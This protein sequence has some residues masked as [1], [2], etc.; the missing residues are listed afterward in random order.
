M[1]LTTVTA[2]AVRPEPGA[3][4]LIPKETYPMF[5]I[6][7][8]VL[9]AILALI[10]FGAAVHILFSPWLLL[11]AVGIFAWIKLRPGRSR[12]PR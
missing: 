9:L 1:N 5:A 12:S 2:G 10:V 8:V 11:V 7:A 6:I 4:S 3:A